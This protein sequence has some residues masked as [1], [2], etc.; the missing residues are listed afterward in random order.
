MKTEKINIGFA[1]LDMMILEAFTALN[2]KGYNADRVCS[3]RG[4]Y[5]EGCKDL[6]M[7]FIVF[8][9]IVRLPSVPFGFEL[10]HVEDK[11]YSALFHRYEDN[12]SCRQVLNRKVKVVAALLFW[13]LYLP[14]N[15]KAR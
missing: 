2:E 12:L 6:P 11:G 3:F 1:Q 9:D 13:V 15:D 4:N 8:K 10:T 5:Y 14:F 7:D